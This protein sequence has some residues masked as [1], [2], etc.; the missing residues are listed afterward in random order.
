M[1][2]PGLPG[3]ALCPPVVSPDRAQAPEPGGHGPPAPAQAWLRS[4]AARLPKDP[5]ALAHTVHMRGGGEARSCLGAGLAGG[6]A[7]HLD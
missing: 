2:T 3:P 7:E 6:R 1:K 5:S 4:P